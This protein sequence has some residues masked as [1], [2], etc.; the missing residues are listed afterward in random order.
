MRYLLTLLLTL[1]LS[2]GDESA[3]PSRNGKDQDQNIDMGDMGV[4]GDTGV[5]GDME[6]DLGTT[7]KSYM[8]KNLINMIHTEKDYEFAVVGGFELEP[9]P[10]EFGGSEGDD[11]G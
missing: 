7:P 10:F 2:C 1:T 3:K 8:N 4:D 5:E 11:E 9:Q 6:L